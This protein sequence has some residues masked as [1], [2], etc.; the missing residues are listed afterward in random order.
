MES[1]WNTQLL[2][3]GSP[4]VSGHSI[5]Q[6]HGKILACSAVTRGTRETAWGRWQEGEPGDVRSCAPCE[7]QPSSPAQGPAFVHQVRDGS[8]L[9]S[10]LLQ[11]PLRVLCILFVR[12]TI[13]L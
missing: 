13:S 11:K 4:S 7:R 8:L 1:V 12:D 10:C 3:H 6:N 2:A 5:P 9:Q